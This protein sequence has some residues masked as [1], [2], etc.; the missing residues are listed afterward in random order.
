[1]HWQSMNR[2]VRHDQMEAT[3]SGPLLC[4]AV[5]DQNILGYGET[6]LIRCIERCPRYSAHLMHSFSERQRA[7]VYLLALPATHR[8][9]LA[10]ASKL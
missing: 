3:S 1:M 8:H 2:S 5:L 9:F 7:T 6:K 4:Y 10:I